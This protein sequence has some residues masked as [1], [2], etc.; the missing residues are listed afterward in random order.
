LRRLKDGVVVESPI[1]CGRFAVDDAVVDERLHCLTVF[2]FAV[3]HKV[4]D[5]YV[6]PELYAGN[7]LRLGDS[8]G[9][10]GCEGLAFVGPRCA[11]IIDDAREEWKIVDGLRERVVLVC[12]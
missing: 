10:D 6:F 11:P 1:A 8:F 2:R 4:P 5:D 9:D 7:S 3:L 12:V